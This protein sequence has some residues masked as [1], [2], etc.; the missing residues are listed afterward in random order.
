MLKEKIYLSGSEHRKQKVVMVCFQR[1]HQI[2]SLLKQ[3]FP[4]YWSQS[5]GCWWIARN[6]F[7]YK[8]FKE[9]FSPIVDIVIQKTEEKEDIILP[10]G[11]LEKL[12]QKRYSPQ[13]IKTYTLYFKDFLRY[14]KEKNLNNISVEQCNQYLL[15]LIKEKGISPSQQNQRINSIKFYY[16]KVL[17]REREY[18]QIDRPK[19]EHKLPSVLSKNEVKKIILHCY[20]RKHRCILSLIYSAGLRR[21]ELIQLEPSDII[22]N[23]NQ[24]KIRGAKG[25]KDRY[26]IISSQ[27]IDELRLYYKEYRPQKWLFE[28]QKAGSQYSTTSVRNILNRACKKAGIKG[29]VTPHM[30]RHSFATHLLEQGVDLRYIQ[31]LLGHSSSK[32]T[33]IYTHVSNHEIGKIKNPL[34]DLL[35]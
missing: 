29:K 27:L 7:D 12:E 3:Y 17:G 6:A 31:V 23:R 15:S 20:N 35:K 13:T 18:Y 24:I 2:I 4:A 14:F 22:A 26:S 9:V 11:Y 25:K 33:E 8:K 16:E 32:T 34:D 10:K 28:G 5:K 21:G 30:L 19:K 1:N